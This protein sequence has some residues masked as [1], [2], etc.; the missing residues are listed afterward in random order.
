MCRID[1]HDTAARPAIDP[2][3]IA[4]SPEI[5][6][7]IQPFA[8]HG[9]R[10]KDQT[11]VEMAVSKAAKAATMGASKKIMAISESRQS[12]FHVCSE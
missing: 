1:N 2:Q 10:L 6:D 5:A 8:A 12:V 3:S 9:L 7:I 4:V 11:S